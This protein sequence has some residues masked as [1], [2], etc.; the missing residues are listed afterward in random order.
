MNADVTELIQK[1]SHRI[2]ARA[3]E[4]GTLADRGDFTGESAN[5]RLDELM[6]I[7]EWLRDEMMEEHR[8][9]EEEVRKALGE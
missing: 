7:Q 4:L 2:D 5:A 8:R 6:Q 9:A 3:K 1:L